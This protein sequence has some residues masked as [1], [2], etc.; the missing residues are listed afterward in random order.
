MAHWSLEGFNEFIGKLPSCF[1]NLLEILNGLFVR[2]RRRFMLRMQ[3]E[4]N[5]RLVFTLWW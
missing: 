2:V 5:S 4:L 1:L 3:R